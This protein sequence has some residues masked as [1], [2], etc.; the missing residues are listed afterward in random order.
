MP[1]TIAAMK[2][3]DRSAASTLSR[4]ASS[5]VASMSVA[6]D[7][8]SL[9]HGRGP[10]LS[11]EAM[12]PAVHL[13]SE[14]LIAVRKSDQF[15]VE[16]DQSSI[17]SAIAPQMCGPIAKAHALSMSRLDRKASPGTVFAAGA[18]AAGA[19]SRLLQRETNLLMGPFLMAQVCQIFPAGRVYASAP[20]HRPLNCGLRFSKKA[21]RPSA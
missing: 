9:W 2:P 1:N 17:T 8:D 5:I 20:I 4:I 7:G 15:L 18:A 10:C 13:P 3:K 19:L 21:R 16:C 14:K 12:R 11:D 6:L